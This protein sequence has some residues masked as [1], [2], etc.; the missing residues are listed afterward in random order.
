MKEL[1]RIDY[2]SLDDK[3]LAGLF[4]SGDPLAVRVLTSRNN[5]RLFRVA[6]SVLK[7]HSEAEDVVQATYLRAFTAISSFEG[8]SALTTW[9]VRIALNEALERKRSARREQ[10]YLDGSSVILLQAY[11]EKLMRG[12]DNG[13]NPLDEAGREQLRKILEEAIARLPENYRIVFVLR[14]I[15]QMSVSE[16][17]EALGIPE[18]TV[19]TRFLRGRKMLQDLISPEI[20]SVL[21]ETFPF[22]GK[23]CAALTAIVIGQIGEKTAKSQERDL[24][25]CELREENG[26]VRDNDMEGGRKM[27]NGNPKST[28]KIAGHPLHPMLIPFPI[29]FLVGTLVSDIVYWQSG[30]AFW[31]SA[32]LYLLSAALVMALLA[33]AAGLTDFLG[34]RR[35]RMISHAWQHM[36]G[37]ITVV[38][39]S[40]INLWVRLD[41]PQGGI[42]PFGLA[43]SAAVGLLLI[44]TGWRGGDLVYRHKVGIPE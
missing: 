23:D 39:L 22:A 21:A 40:A 38:L 5:R 41:D 30:S 24:G 42:L 33:A 35:I 3:T 7:D 37:N 43:L 19:K 2:Q 18:G 17:A 9:L 1:R 27:A 13:S 15:E 29:A 32:S 14:E 20:R 31:A 28:A 36:I 4:A 11:R 6:W 44:F 8:R 26:F 25:R 10:E 12:S 34:D 16:V